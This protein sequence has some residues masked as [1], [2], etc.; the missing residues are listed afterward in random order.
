[1]CYVYFVAGASDSLILFKFWNISRFLL[2][3][4]SEISNG[5]CLSSIV[6]PSLI[7]CSIMSWSKVI[8]IM[9]LQSPMN[10]LMSSFSYLQVQASLIQVVQI[11]LCFF[12]C[13]VI[14]YFHHLFPPV[15][16]LSHILLFSS[17]V[18]P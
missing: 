2:S 14:P 1:M 8:L 15:T 18:F 13:S 6:F 4:F 10:F 5:R 12:F 17:L 16:S 7:A 3:S 11:Q 9:L